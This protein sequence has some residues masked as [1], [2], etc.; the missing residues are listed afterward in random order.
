[1]NKDCQVGQLTTSKVVSLKV[2]LFTDTSRATIMI[3]DLNQN[4][5]N[6]SQTKLPNEY[7]TKNP[8]NVIEPEKEK[9]TKA[10]G[11]YGENA[12]RDAEMVGVEVEKRK[13]RPFERII[14][15]R[16]PDIDSWQPLDK[17]PS[18]SW[19]GGEASSSSS[20]D[21]EHGEVGEDGED[22]ERRPKAGKSGVIAKILEPG[23]ALPQVCDKPST[24]LNSTAAPQ[25]LVL[26]A[27]TTNFSFLDQLG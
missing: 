7:V 19:E 24:T 25:E 21:G 22:G 15:G 11:E 1:M 2:R 17:K 16:E 8:M 20:A 27:S 23:A 12:A 5:K 10:P 14:S 4:K 9:P 13:A 6:D 18:S 26:R 3:V